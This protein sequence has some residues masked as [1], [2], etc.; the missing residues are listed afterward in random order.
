[1]FLKRKHIVTSARTMRA[2]RI[3]RDGDSGKLEPGTTAIAPPGIGE[4]QIKVAYAGINRADL[5]QVE[6]SYP[7]PA[8]AVEIPGLEVSG[9]IAALGA[10]AVGW[11]TGENVCALC[12]EGGYAEYVNVPAEQVLPLPSGL[13]L[14]ESASLP[15]GCATGFMALSQLAHLKYGQRTLVHGGS[16]GTGIMIAQLARIIGGEVYATASGPEKSAFLETLNIRPLDH[17]ASDWAE[18]LRAATLDQGVDV[19]VDILGAPQLATHFKLLRRGGRLISLAFMEGNTAESLKISPIMM[20]QLTWTGTTLR[21]KTATEKKLIMR[22][23]Y[24]SVWPH[25]AAKRMVPVVDQ[26]FPLEEAE[27]AHQRMQE[28]LHIGKILLEVGP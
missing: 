25:F 9:T 5:L 3:I 7:A 6:G 10:G 8:G 23:V 15:E 11:N 17:Q 13:D 20:K 18:Q 22:S 4:V 19:I 24:R 2:V 14:K 27:K 12:S 16:S 28:R 26:I 21:S 1:M